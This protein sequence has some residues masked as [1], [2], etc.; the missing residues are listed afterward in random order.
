MYTLTKGVLFIL[1]LCNFSALFLSCSESPTKSEEI[2]EVQWTTIIKLDGLPDNTIG[3]IIPGP[4]G[5]L[6]CVLL[7]EGVQGFMPH[8]VPGVKCGLKII[9][10]V[11]RHILRAL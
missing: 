3:A 11:S 9:L 5:A 10:P 7:P 8:A 4:D 1:M 2:Q 6:W